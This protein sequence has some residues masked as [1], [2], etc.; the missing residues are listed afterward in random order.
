VQTR[1]RNGARDCS[2]SKKDTLLHRRHLRNRYKGVLKSNLCFL[3]GV[4]RERSSLSIF[5]AD[6]IDRRMVPQ[7]L[8]GKY[9]EL[10]QL[11]GGWGKNFISEG[12]GSCPGD[13]LL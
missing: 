4:K 3:R 10:V 5:L 7:G 12:W 13:A 9:L 11:S 8:L 2:P 1:L 6:L